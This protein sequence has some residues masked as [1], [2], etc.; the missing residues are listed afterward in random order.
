M[1]VIYLI[2]NIGGVVITRVK[3]DIDDR[4]KVIHMC[5]PCYTLNWRDKIWQRFMY[6][7][8]FHFPWLYLEINNNCPYLF[9]DYRLHAFDIGKIMEIV[10]IN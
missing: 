10:K 8:D 6:L 4:K 7:Y 3:Y 5:S 9:H 2:E 1:Y